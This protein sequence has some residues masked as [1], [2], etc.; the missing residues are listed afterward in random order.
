MYDFSYTVNEYDPSQNKVEFGHQEERDGYRTSGSYYVLLPDTRTLKVSY[1]AD[2]TGFHPTITYEGEASYPQ[3]QTYQQ[4]SQS[5]SA[6][7]RR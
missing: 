4:P 7:G 1:Y 6:P 5:Y 3:Q 2:D